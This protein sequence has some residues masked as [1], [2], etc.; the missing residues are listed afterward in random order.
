MESIKKEALM[1]LRKVS[2]NYL[3][4]QYIAIRKLIKQYNL[5][6]DSF[7]RELLMQKIKNLQKIIK[8]QQLIQACG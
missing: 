3:D 8:N 2:K 7:K 6:D 1:V 5:E 4:P